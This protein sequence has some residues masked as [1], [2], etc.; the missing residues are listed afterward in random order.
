MNY[1]LLLKIENIKKSFDSIEILKDISLEIYKS[2]IITIFGHSGV[3]KS[4]LLSIVT[5]MLTSNIGK[6]F[7]N[8]VEMDNLNNSDLR[9]KYMGIL[10]QKN[11]LLPEFNVKENLLLPL[12]I[13]NKPYNEGIKRVNELLDFLHLHDLISR[14]PATLSRGEY[15]RISLLKSIANEPA[16]VI[17]DEPTANL[18]EN[19]CK[20]LIDLIVKLNRD[21]N[22]TFLIA[23]HDKRFTKISNKTYKLFDGRLNKNE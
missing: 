22:V 18:D 19:N 10:F 5:G 7:I 4:T 6:I 17:A 1:K 13:N 11:N 12:I 2:D 9:R 15:Q 16:I 21:L 8:K 3:G 14:M 23:S 20:Q